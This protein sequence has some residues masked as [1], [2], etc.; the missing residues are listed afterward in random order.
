VSKNEAYSFSEQNVSENKKYR[1]IEKNEK[2]PYVGTGMCFG[3]CDGC[4][5][6]PEY[7]SRGRAKR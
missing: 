4:Y 3:T 5:W 1:R 2:D 7:S 6:L